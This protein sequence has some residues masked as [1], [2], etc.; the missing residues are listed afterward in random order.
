MWHHG[1]FWWQK[2]AMQKLKI[3]NGRSFTQK[4]AMGGV[5]GSGS[6]LKKSFSFIFCKNCLILY[7][8]KL[9]AFEMW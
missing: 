3:C 4:Y 7:L 6:A 1:N 8:I 9:K 5:L 2:L